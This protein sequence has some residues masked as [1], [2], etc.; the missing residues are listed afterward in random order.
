MSKKLQQKQQR[1]LAE[2]AKRARRKKEHRRANLITIGIAA[3][4]MIAV[5]AVVIVQRG[6]GGPRDN[7]GVS[8]AEANCGELETFPSEG[9]NHVQVG[10]PVNYQANPPTTGNHW[11]P[12]AISDPGFYEEQVPAESVVHNQEHGQ[13]VIWYDP[14][15]PQEVIDQIE[16]LVQQSPQVNIAAPWEDI[17]DPYNYVL[18]AWDGAG[19]QGAQMRC[20]LP[21]QQVWDEFRADYQGRGPES[22]GIPTFSAD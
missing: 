4:V 3:A 1:R 12:E 6:G 18:G 19:E 8:A 5:V 22:V 7:V 14:E 13:I 17:E 20:E 9:N 11:P 10:T 21:S 16:D 15:A 2:E